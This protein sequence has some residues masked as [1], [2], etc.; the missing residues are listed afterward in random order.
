MHS[1]E[2]QRLLLWGAFLFVC[3]LIYQTWVEE[4][5]PPPNIAPIMEN[6]GASSDL[7]TIDFADDRPSSLPTEGSDVPIMPDD[8]IQIAKSMMV[9]SGERIRVTTDV[10]DLEIDTRGGTINKVDLVQHR[11]EADVSE[12]PFRMFDDSMDN[13]YIAQSG[14]LGNQDT[15][16]HKALFKASQSRYEMSNGEEL[17]VPL[18]W[19]SESGVEVIK[20]FVFTPGDHLVQIEYAVR[21]QTTQPWSARAYG[22]LQHGGENGDTKSFFMNT[23]LGGAISTEEKNYEKVKFK[24]FEKEKLN[25]KNSG[26][27]IAILQHYFVA[28]WVPEQDQE[29]H[30]YT[31]QRPGPRYIIGVMTPAVEIAAGDVGQLH[32]KL[33]VGPK[34]QQRLKEIAPYLDLAVDYGWLWFLAKPLFW[35]LEF[36]YGLVGNWGIAIIMV[37]IVVKVIFFHPSMVSYRSMANMRRIQPKMQELKERLGDDRQAMGQAVMK[38]YKEE[39]VNPLGGCLPILI[40]MPVFIALY[41]VLLESVEMRHAPFFLWLDDLS[42]M[43]PFFILPLLMGASMFFQQRLNPTPPDPV[44]AKVMQMMPI[45]FTVFFAFFPSGLVLYWLSNNVLS[46]AQQWYITKQVEAT[47]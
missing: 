6:S 22:Q 28:A 13:F 12:V 42:S 19:Q 43:D 25:L 39:K 33:Y 40:Q 47:S 41:W 16:D 3:V 44:Q 36:F 30:F 9:P 10:M 46:I 35:L 2:T 24:N 23:Y 21:N 38:L 5:R 14:L 18:T 4:H 17:R 11:A 37:T 34:D 31:D 26:V 45:M 27:W 32:S 7:P 29:N 20:T 1:L 15:P 8:P